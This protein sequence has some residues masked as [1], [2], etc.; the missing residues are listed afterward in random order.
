MPPRTAT[1]CL[2]GDIASRFLAAVLAHDNVK[3]LQDQRYSLR[4]EVKRA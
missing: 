3:G 2:Q 4:R 1:G